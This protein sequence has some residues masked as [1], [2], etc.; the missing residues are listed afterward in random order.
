MLTPQQHTSG[1]NADPQLRRLRKYVL[2]PALLCLATFACFAY[3]LRGGFRH[4]QIAPYKVPLAAYN[5][6][7]DVLSHPQNIS[8]VTLQTGVIRMDACLNLDPASPRQKQCDHAPRDLAVLV[9]WIHHPRFGDFLIDTGF[10]D[11]FANHPPYGN[12]TEAMKLF[13][14]VHGVTNGQHPG[15]DLSAQLAR[16]GH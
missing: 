2:P 16:L 6:W 10:D 7:N 14:W 3:L 15:D 12:Y 1:R 4:F 13:N 11:S 9:H 5:T 8:L